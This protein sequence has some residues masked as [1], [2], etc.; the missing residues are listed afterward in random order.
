MGRGPAAV[1]AGQGDLAHARL[2]QD[3]G[4]QCRIVY[5]DHQ[6]FERFRLRR[7]SSDRADLQAAAA[8]VATRD[9][10]D[11]IVLARY[12]GNKELAGRLRIPEANLDGRDSRDHKQAGERHETP[13]GKRIPEAAEDHSKCRLRLGLSMDLALY[14]R[15]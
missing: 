8:A 3:P 2:W 14:L 5:L 10:A 6:E 4:R 15:K 7:H 9:K 1:L 13:E 11:G 12:F